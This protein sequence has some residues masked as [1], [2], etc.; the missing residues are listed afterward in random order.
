MPKCLWMQED[1]RG[2]QI[3]HRA[4]VPNWPRGFPWNR[5]ERTERKQTFEETKKEIS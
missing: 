4:N 2:H 5:T 1:R 3:K